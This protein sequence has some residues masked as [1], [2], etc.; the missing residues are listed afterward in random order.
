[1]LTKCL[2]GVDIEYDGYWVKTDL[3]V[4]DDS[5]TEDISLGKPSMGQLG[6]SLR[7]P[8]GQNIWTSKDPL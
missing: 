5:D 2:I 6:F 4:H 1:M 8:R 7:V 3:W